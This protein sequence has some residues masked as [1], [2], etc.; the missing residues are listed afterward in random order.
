M[1]GGDDFAKEVQEYIS[2]VDAACATA[3]DGTIAQMQEHF[4]MSCRLEH[5][6]RTITRI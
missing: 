5:M 1:Y 2:I 6:V 3:D 4:N